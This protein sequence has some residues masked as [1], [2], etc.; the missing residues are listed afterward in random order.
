VKVVLT[1]EAEADIRDIVNYIAERNAIAALRLAARLKTSCDAL[2]TNSRV[3][4][5]VPRYHQHGIRRRV[6]GSYLIFYRIKP[7]EI[8][9]LHIL[10]GA[11]D[12]ESVL[13]PDA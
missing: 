10:H 3:Y 7:D 2:A 5:L 4:P 8:E 12:Y 9:V 13:F 6:V 11:R 1:S